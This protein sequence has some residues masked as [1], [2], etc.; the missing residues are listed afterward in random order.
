MGSKSLSWVCGRI[1]GRSDLN[2]VYCVLR[3]RVV[4]LVG[5]RGDRLDEEE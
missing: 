5:R 3:R 2:L 1:R 4:F